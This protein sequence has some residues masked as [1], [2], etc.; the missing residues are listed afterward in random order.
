MVGLVRGLH[1]LH[2]AVRVESLSDDPGRFEVGSLLHPEGADER[3]TV[4]WSQE[5]GPGVLVRFRELTSRDEA[6]SLRDR[7]LEAGVTREALAEGSYYWHELMDVQV[8]TSDGEVLGIVTDVFRA[9][10][11]EVF[12]VDGGQRGEILIP[13]VRAIVSELAPRQGRIVVHRD[14]LDLA[15]QPATKRPRGRR[16]TRA[17]RVSAADSGDASPQTTEQ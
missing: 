9:G 11:G 15:G 5:D 4:A 14:A 16:T 12:A 2:G 1:G 8:T 7:Y 17:L 3:L 10:G 13:A 6:E